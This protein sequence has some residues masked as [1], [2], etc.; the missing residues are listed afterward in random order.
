MTRMTAVGGISVIG[1]SETAAIRV[2]R[3]IRG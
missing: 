2:I 1:G 3:A